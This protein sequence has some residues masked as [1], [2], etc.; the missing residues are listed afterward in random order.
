MISSTAVI[1]IFQLM[2]PIHTKFLD[3]LNVYF[4]DIV[5][6]SMFTIEIELTVRI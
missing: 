2:L 5:K 3:F 1:E 4:L 6:D